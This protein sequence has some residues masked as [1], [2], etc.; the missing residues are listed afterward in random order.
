LPAQPLFF[1]FLR[2]NTIYIQKK[3]CKKNRI[4]IFDWEYALNCYILFEIAP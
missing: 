1:I 3:D 2:E 4:K